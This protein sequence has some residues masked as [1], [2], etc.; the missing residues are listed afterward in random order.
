[1]KYL[2]GQE[3]IVR[4][5]DG[6]LKLYKQYPEM[7]A[8]AVVKGMSFLFP[9]PQKRPSFYLDGYTDKKVFGRNCFVVNKEGK[10]ATIIFEGE[11]EL[12]EVDSCNVFD[13]EETARISFLEE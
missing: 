4:L 6:V 9:E 1:M 11:V 7:T 5:V 13:D 2:I 3:D 8:E 10:T 12:L